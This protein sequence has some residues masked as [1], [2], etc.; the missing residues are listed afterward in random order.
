MATNLFHQMRDNCV[1]VTI[2][3]LSLLGQNE[4][5]RKIWGQFHQHFTC[6][7]FVQKFVQSQTLRREK[8]LK[9]LLNKKYACKMLMKLTSWLIF[10]LVF[11][12]LTQHKY[13]FYYPRSSTFSVNMSYV[14]DQH[15]K[16]TKSN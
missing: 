16:Y 8:L 12:F 5:G 11:Q 6:A 10:L 7:F 9:R 4:D 14:T 2:E 15:E 13:C 1:F 3:L